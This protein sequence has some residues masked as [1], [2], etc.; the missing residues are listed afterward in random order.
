MPRLPPDPALAFGPDGAPRALAEDDVYFSAA[1]GLAETI[2]VFHAGCDLPAAWAGGA[3][4]AIGELGFGTGLNALATRALWRRTRAPG[5]ILH[6]VSVE[7]RPMP[8]QA[9]A[10]ALAAFPDLSPLSEELIARWPFRA[11]GAQRLWFAEDGFCLTILIGEVETML[12]GRTEPMDAWFLDGFAPARNPSMWSDAV[13]GQVAR[14]TKAGGRAATYTVAGAVRRGLAAHAFSVL[15]QRGFGSKRE[16]LE[17]VKTAPPPPRAS[18]FPEAPT[19]HARSALVIGGGVA[20]A[21]MADAFARRGLAVTLFDDDPCGQTKSS[22]NPAALVMPRLDRGE[23]PAARFLREAY[24]A[25]LAR[26]T[27]LGPEA[28]EPCG[29]WEPAQDAADVQ[30]LADFAADPPLPPALLEVRADGLWHAGAGVAYPAAVVAALRVHAT[31]RPERVAALIREGE[32]WIAAGD[33]GQRLAAAPLCVV[34]SGPALAAFEQARFLPIARGRGQISAGP[35]SAPP[36]HPSAAGGYVLPFGDQ[37]LFGAT[38]ETLAPGEVAGPVS[39]AAHA[40]NLAELAALAPGLAE[41]L[42]PSQLW[43]RV[44]IRPTTPDRMPIAGPIP[45]EPAYRAAFASLAH[46]AIPREAEPAPQHEGLHALGGLGSRGFTTAFLCAEIVASAALGEP[47]P[48]DRAAWE[49]VQ[50]T[51]FLI[52]ALKRGG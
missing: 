13:L 50:P 31:R 19:P 47:A 28:F 2:A 22:H 16:R 6:F 45:D 21:A 52:R 27:A 41:G 12:S 40:A 48:T 26:L 4:F 20:G 34:A 14:L 49:A 24:L 35:T 44:S 10:R 11:A 23:T 37:L 38:H 15:K 36:K 1:N 39:P 18:L 46:G 8:A 33:D 32:D 30:R 17:A 29:V 9:A 5:A 51:R 25:A 43:G 7:G 42:K 3:Q